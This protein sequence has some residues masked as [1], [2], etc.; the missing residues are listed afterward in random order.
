MNTF[1]ALA[2]AASSFAFATAAAAA[3]KTI[4][5][6]TASPSQQSPSPPATPDRAPR[7]AINGF[8]Y[9]GGESL[10]QVAPHRFVVIAGRLV[11]SSECDHAIRAPATA[12]TIEELEALRARN[13]GG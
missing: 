3:G 10:W 1:R 5:A 13:P 8:E 2:L 7:G 6:A 11:H 4:E 12:P 9:I